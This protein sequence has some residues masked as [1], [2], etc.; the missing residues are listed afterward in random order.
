MLKVFALV[1]ILIAAAP[2]S[3]SPAP[4][5]PDE[6]FSR[7]ALRQARLLIQMRLLQLHDERLECIRAALLRQLPDA[8]WPDVPSPSRG[9]SDAA[10]AAAKC[11]GLEKF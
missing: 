1:S 3:P 11:A 2:A 6:L 8:L 5:S 7:R 4:R 9:S 10:A